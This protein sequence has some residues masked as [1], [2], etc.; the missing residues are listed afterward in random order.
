[1]TKVFV[2]L[3]TVTESKQLQVSS[4]EADLLVGMPNTFCKGSWGKCELVL[5]VAVV[6]PSYEY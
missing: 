5:K 6:R 3:N 4:T 1:M 2:N